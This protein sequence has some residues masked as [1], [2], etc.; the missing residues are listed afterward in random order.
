MQEE[1]NAG[2]MQQ[3]EAVKANWAALQELTQTEE[4]ETVQQNQE[5]APDQTADTVD[6]PDPQGLNT[7]KDDESQDSDKT[8]EEK[9]DVENKEDKTESDPEKK[10]D[11]NQETEFQ[12]TADDIKDVP[13]TFEDGTFRALAHEL[14]VDLTE[15]SFDAF[16]ESFVPKTELEKVKQATIENIY[17][18][19]KNPE[20]V[21]ALKMME[22]GIPEDQAFAPT[23]QIDGWLSLEDSNLVRLNLENTEGW[24]PELIDAKMEE[25]A[26]DPKKLALA[27]GEIRI[28]L[29]HERK[30]IVETRNH[31]LQQ[32][33]SQKQQLSMQ[34]V[35]EEKA[36][37]K[38]ALNN[39]S[40]FFGHSLTKE[41]KDAIIA[42][43]DKGLYDNE[44][45][46]ADAQ[47]TAI[48]YKEY[49][50][51]LRKLIQNKASEDA[52]VD[53]RKKLLNTPPVS[54]KAGNM[55]KPTNQHDNNWGAILEDF[56]G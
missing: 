51:K 20:T 53:T 44:L 33:E 36:Q 22:M 29:N 31:L 56:K 24:T 14:G 6:N 49:G 1:Q 30:N 4:T 23:K 40:Q 13:E 38:N 16:K 35:A 43:Y 55:V 46:K 42:K 7:E 41:A 34:R 11:E 15:E 45:K 19:L 9:K 37:F 18:E 54:G 5:T 28:G 32:Y 3:Q 17:A 50:D 12:L 39:A 52:K 21:V 25:L 10:T 26:A 48:L 27:A 8:E 2:V 47:V